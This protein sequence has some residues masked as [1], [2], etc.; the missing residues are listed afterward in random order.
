MFDATAYARQLRQLFPRGSLWNFEAD[1]V[2]S[3]VL[4]A[5]GDELARVGERAADLQDEADPRTA[6]ETLEDWER[7]LG[8]PDS[9]LEEIPSSVSER[10]VAVAARFAAR[11]G[12]SAQFYIDLAATLGYT[13]TIDE[14]TV[15]R[16]GVMRS[17]DRCNGTAWAYAW[18]VTIEGYEP[19]AVSIF[20]AGSGR[21]GDRLQG[22][23]QLDLECIL[24]RAKPAHTQVLFNYEV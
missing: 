7:I 19:G 1:S 20:R 9:C 22:F 4:L 3:R 15:C 12:Q 2:L 23:E 24:Q 16:S 21:S 5:I 6:L 10:R 17:G 14:Y 18:L 11:G 8:L 13:I